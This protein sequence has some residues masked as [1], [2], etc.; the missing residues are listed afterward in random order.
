MRT[1]YYIFG[2]VCY[3]F[4][5]TFLTCL[6]CFVCVFEW[7]AKEDT[8]SNRCKCIKEQISIFVQVA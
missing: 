4:V 7:V 1:L 3:C 6:G 2:I 8:A 5:F